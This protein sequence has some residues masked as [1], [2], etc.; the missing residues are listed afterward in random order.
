M[1]K[2]NN[3]GFIL[4]FF[5]FWEIFLCTTILH[6]YKKLS[7]I[8]PAFNEEKT[9]SEIIHRVR[10][11]S[12]APLEKE[13]IVVDDA[14]CDATPDILK[15]M[16]G[17]VAV[18]HKKNSGKGAAIKT[19]LLQAT[20]DIILIQDADMEYNPDD[21]PK[22]LEPIL[23]GQ[24]DLVMGSRFL[25]EKPK[26]FTK[27]GNPFFTHYIGNKTIIWI[28]NFLYKKRFTDYEGGYKCFTKTL[29][30]KIP[31]KTDS[32]DFDNE[33]VCEALRK[34]FVIKE[35]PIQYDPRLYS[36]GKKIN[37]KHGLKILWTIARCRLSKSSS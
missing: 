28:T 37:W 31:V 21:Y 10:N 25:L 33:L 22:L 23:K 7:V 17:I 27:D 36:E 13:I 18:F 19:G 15:D 2:K 32:F 11:V 6:M 34:K 1:S 26:F 20:G 24:A 35:V 5:Y 29:S 4:T 30:D 12:I 3:V 9:I 16:K 8:I 14:S